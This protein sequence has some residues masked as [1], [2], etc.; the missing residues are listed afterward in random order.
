MKHF[1]A[2]K[3]AL[4]LAFASQIQGSAMVEQAPAPVG[5]SY[6]K[7]PLFADSLYEAVPSLH[8]NRCINAH[9]GNAI[10][11]N[12]M[13]GAI[14]EAPMGKVID[15]FIDC[16]DVMSLVYHDKIILDG[17]DDLLRGL[18]AAKTTEFYEAL[19]SVVTSPE[20][21]P[22]SV[23]AVKAIYKASLIKG[24]PRDL[25]M[26]DM[27]LDSKHCIGALTEM[28]LKSTDKIALRAFLSTE[29]SR[30]RNSRIERA[31]EAEEVR[32][33]IDFMDNLFN[34]REASTE[35]MNDS[36]K[37]NAL[38]LALSLNRYPLADR[39]VGLMRKNT[40]MAYD[41]IEFIKD[42]LLDR[43]AEPMRA[44]RIAAKLFGTVKDQ[45]DF[46]RLLSSF[47]GQ[48]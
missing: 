14:Y 45:T 26:N 6:N 10:N 32:R 22:Q 38:Y 27:I 42:V 41:V 12:S 19:R 30:F 8:L 28:A 29:M 39:T 21:H 47:R 16:P 36:S 5:L 11:D 15:A 35:R 4:M 31:S 20:S 46:E 44:L 7:F 33:F 2:S 24:I 37:L 17:A 23:T 9:F 3:I 18:T 34:D 48:I 40:E 13:L 43:I 25:Y 1:S